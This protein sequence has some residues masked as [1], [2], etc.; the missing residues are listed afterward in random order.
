MGLLIL[1]LWYD[2]L[3]VTNLY[4]SWFLA[5]VMLWL[6]G[7]LFGRSMAIAGNYFPYIEIGVFILQIGFT[8]ATVALY[9]YAA[10][11]TG[12]R[13]RVFQIFSI[14]ATV[15]LF[16]IQ[17][18]VVVIGTEPNYGRTTSGLL[19]YEF[20]QSTML[21]FSTMNLAVLVLVWRGFRRIQRPAL[22]FGIMLF[23]LGQ[24]VSLVSPRLQTLAVAENAASL[25][26]F[27]MAFS[28]VQT[29]II[30][31]LA[32]QS[33]QIEIVRDVGA[34]I[35]SRLRLKNVLQTVA[36]QAALFLEA[37]AC[38]IFLI[39]PNEP[40]LELAAQYNI[41]DNLLGY[42]I[43]LNEGVAGKVAS[44]RKSV[45]ISD[46]RNQWR[47]TPDMPF[48]HDGFG[49][50][51]GVP[52][53]FRDDVVGALLVI[54]GLDARIFEPEDVQLLQ[55]LAPQAA[56]AITN[57]RLFEAQQALTVELETAK[58]QLEAFL[59]SADNPVIA[60]NRHM[61]IIF[62]NEAAAKLIADDS[63]DLRGQF[64]LDIASQSYLPPDTANLLR[65]IRLQKSHIYELTIENHTYLAH[66]TR[67]QEP[68]KGWVVVLNDVTSLKELDRLQ[69]Q[70]IELTTHQLK[71]PLQGAMLHLDELE[72]LGDGILTEDM[73]YD[74]S[75]IWEQLKRM[76]RLI[77]G[78]LSLERLQNRMTRTE[79][80]DFT[81]IVQAATHTLRDLARAKQI[82]LTV[83]IEDNLPIIVGDP[84]ELTE[85]VT[86]LVDNAIKYTPDYGSIDVIACEDSESIML[87]VRDTG[88]GIPDTEYQKVFERFYRV[89][90]SGTELIGGTGMGLSLVKAIVD[91]HKG[92]IWIE[93]SIGDGT[94]FFV[95]LPMLH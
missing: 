23:S 47:E 57:S 42:R 36:A 51:I 85:V 93:S 21:L 84:K 83:D 53:I 91:A 1:L 38:I 54:N 69:R 7:S 66:L 28:L 48:A 2:A 86:N 27:I 95:T 16:V 70:M 46:Y 11:L 73:E 55:L 37:D 19:L 3:R 34:A 67:I 26:T 35:T 31:P 45:L 72:D 75:V 39:E 22:A 82:T 71:N 62:A 14:I 60:L 13:T 58:T 20:P 63:P 33:R 78:I 43:N 32:G 64:L 56:V 74:L 76:Q 4:F 5:M 41:H 40:K 65:D 6:G 79:Q 44:D 92:Q 24:L 88:I 8:G 9:F 59:S 80:V 81:Q 90:Q 52:L 18:F 77:D 68:Q 61:H 50:V 87:K 15:I 94:T 17:V 29:Q 89:E 30:K 25:A 49:S 10:V 12:N